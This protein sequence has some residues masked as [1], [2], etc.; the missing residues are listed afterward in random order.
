MMALLAMEPTRASLIRLSVNSFSAA[1]RIRSC[2][3]RGSRA[4]A[5]LESISAELESF[6]DSN[7]LDTM[8]RQVTVKLPGRSMLDVRCSVFDAGYSMLMLDAGCCAL[9]R[10]G[11]QVLKANSSP[12]SRR[13][14]DSERA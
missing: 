6:I 8:T 11:R 7:R 10:D 13:R 5:F 14:A 1:A 3:R 2:V 4:A 9:P 12:S